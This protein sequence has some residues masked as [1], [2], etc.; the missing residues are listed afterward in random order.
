MTKNLRLI[1]ILVVLF[2]VVAPW[3]LWGGPPRPGGFTSPPGRG[4][5][6]VDWHVVF[7]EAAVVGAGLFLRW[8]RVWRHVHAHRAE[9]GARERGD[10][11][12]EM[13]APP[14]LE[15]DADGTRTPAEKPGKSLRGPK[16]NINIAVAFSAL[17]C[18]VA[19]PGLLHATDHLGQQAIAWS[20][21]R[22]PGT[23][24]FTVL[25]SMIL[26]NVLVIIELALDR[27]HKHTGASQPR[28]P[29]D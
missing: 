13:N 28:L 27:R 5:S 20:D 8:R 1:V 3:I 6:S 9:S 19:M 12:E 11:S 24:N 18:L 15:A 26:T 17:L 21:L 2:V 14:L 16:P 22:Q 7:G 4:H 29:L 23:T 10:A 25:V